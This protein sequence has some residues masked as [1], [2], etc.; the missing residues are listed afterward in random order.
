VFYLKLVMFDALFSTKMCLVLFIEL[1][2][3]KVVE[4]FVLAVMD[5]HV[6]LPGKAGLFPSFASQVRVDP[7]AGAGTGTGTGAGAAGAGATVPES[8]TS[9]GGMPAGAG[10]LAVDLHQIVGAF[11]CESDRSPPNLDCGLSEWEHFYHIH[12]QR[13]RSMY[14]AEGGGGLA[15]FGGVHSVSK[16]SSASSSSKFSSSGFIRNNYWTAPNPDSGTSFSI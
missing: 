13:T 15:D 5:V 2:V 8:P 14:E 4:P 1:D 12:T 10:V 16:L 3:P 11:S 6:T 7:S 9:A